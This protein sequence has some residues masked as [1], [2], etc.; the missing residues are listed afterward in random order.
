M[1]LIHTKVNLILDT[2]MAHLHSLCRPQHNFHSSGKFS[3]IMYVAKVEVSHA[4]NLEYIC[5]DGKCVF[6]PRKSNMQI[7]KL[8]LV[9]TSTRWQ[10]LKFLSL[11]FRNF[12]MCLSKKKVFTSREPTDS[13][14]KKVID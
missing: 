3:K 6:G 10:H 12:V 4:T 9:L 1:T 2:W 14:K 13:A 11:D 7:I 8:L 5:Y